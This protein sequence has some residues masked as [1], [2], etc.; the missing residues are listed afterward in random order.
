MLFQ[1]PQCDQDN[2]E[3]YLGKTESQ[4]SEPLSSG[5]EIHAVCLLGC[6]LSVAVMVFSVSSLEGAHFA[7]R[8]SIF[9]NLN[10]ARD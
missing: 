1:P 10:V 8:L 5:V 3:S 6:Q 4:L 2:C 9:Q 7:N